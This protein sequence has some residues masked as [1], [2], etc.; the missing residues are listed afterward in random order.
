MS[1]TLIDRGRQFLGLAP[2]TEGPNIPDGS[3]PWPRE[4]DLARI[5][6]YDR[7][8]KMFDGRHRELWQPNRKQEDGPYVTMNY[9]QR[10]AKLI[11]ARL[12]GVNETIQ[13]GVSKD[14]LA[15][16]EEP[17]ETPD[18]APAAEQTTLEPIDEPEE[19]DDATPWDA[20]IQDILEASDWPALTYMG[21]V[22]AVSKG[23]AVFRVIYEAESDSV[24]ILCVHPENY[25][26]VFDPEDSSKV[27]QASISWL[28]PGETKDVAWLREERHTPGLIE[29]LL[30]RLQK[31]PASGLDADQWV[32]TEVALTTLPAFAEVE[33]TVE[34][35]IDVIPVVHIANEP[36]VDT[37]PWGVSDFCNFDEAQAATNNRRTSVNAILDRH[38]APLL[39][40]DESFLDEFGNFNAATTKV[41][42]I[43]QDE[44]KPEFLTW[45]GSVTDSQQEAMDLEK[46]QMLLAGASPESFGLGEGGAAESGT[47][48]RLRQ[49]LTTTTVGSKQLTWKPG[50]QRVISVGTKLYDVH[51]QKTSIPRPLQPREI[52]ITFGDGLPRDETGDIEIAVMVKGAGLPVTDKTILMTW[53]FPDWDEERADAELKAFAAQGEA[54]LVAMRPAGIGGGTQLAETGS[55][56][57]RL[58]ANR[59]QVETEGS[60][61]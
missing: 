47:A 21:V 52:E 58:G 5:R 46:R 34:T 3:M 45:D 31:V 7:L 56:R 24:R 30:W 23:D 59:E 60:E 18:G 35:G 14:V 49:M 10:I 29:N 37:K 55:L 6:G 53:I 13:V 36:N 44:V 17:E 25:F 50:L 9:S 42:P 57:E 28:L 61:E 26:P 22:G 32:A 19:R 8:E 2:K 27:I 54:K 12:A 33:P 11:G 41:V 39:A 51:V 1:P 48:L 38:A 4:P 40:V 15:D 43:V 20:A 16:I